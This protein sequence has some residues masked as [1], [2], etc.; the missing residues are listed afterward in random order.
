MTKDE[1]LINELN[2]LFLF[3]PPDR[4]SQSINQVFFS[5]LADMKADPPSD[6]ELIIEDIYFFFFFLQKAEEN[7]QREEM[8]P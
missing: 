7:L 2:D 6:F 5:Y 4:L 3:A 1:I 8:K